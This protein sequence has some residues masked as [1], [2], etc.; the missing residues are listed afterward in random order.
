M[1]AK[2]DGFD[3]GTRTCTADSKP[4]EYVDFFYVELAGPHLALILYI[5]IY[6]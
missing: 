2:R 3:G 1:M 5:Y 6:I 4:T